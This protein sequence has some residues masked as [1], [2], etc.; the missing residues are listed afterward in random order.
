MFPDPLYSPG[1]DFIAIANSLTTRMIE[2]DFEGALN[3]ETVANCN[4]IYLSCLTEMFLD[5]YRGTYATFGHCQVFT[6]KHIWDAGLYFSLAAQLVFQGMLE[7]VELIPELLEIAER[8]QSLNRR[9]QLMF[10]DWV[11]MA[12]SHESYEWLDMTTI[13]LLQLLVLDLHSSKSADEV[14]SV[15]QLNLDRLEELAQV[16]FLQ[17]VRE[18][19]PD[20]LARC[21][22]ARWLHVWAIGLDPACWEAD[23]LFEP[24]TMPRSLRSMRKNLRGVFV[25]LSKLAQR[26]DTLAARIRSTFRAKVFYASVQVFLFL[27]MKNQTGL[28]PR[29]FFVKE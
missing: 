4:R 25:P 9:M 3:E 15:L 10:R 7:H 23:G 27:F 29:M 13:P 28:W 8:Y 18:C 1:T 6:A 22:D 19:V 24:E 17:A 16:I 2:L 20:Q 11:R 12:P 14:R 21:L 26:R 5:T